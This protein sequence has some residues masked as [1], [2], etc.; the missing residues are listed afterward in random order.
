MINILILINLPACVLRAWVGQP[1]GGRRDPKLEA[2]Q[3]VVVVLGSIL[4]I[5]VCIYIYIYIYIYA[6][7]IYI[8]IYTY[9]HTYYLIYY[10]TVNLYK[11]DNNVNTVVITNTTRAQRTPG[12][13]SRPQTSNQ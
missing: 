6:S 5:H 3:A 7:I 1:D 2:L 8:Y 9:V 10:H 11:Y 12:C 13:R 4:Y